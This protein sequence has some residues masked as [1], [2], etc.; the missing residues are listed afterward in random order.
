MPRLWL[1]MAGAQ[2]PGI[3]GEEPRL[4]L[5]KPCLPRGLYPAPVQ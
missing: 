5:A 2:T 1:G 4:P 3:Q